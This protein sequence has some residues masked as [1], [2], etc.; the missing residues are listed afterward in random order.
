MECPFCKGTIGYYQKNIQSYNQL[1][2]WEGKAIDAEEPY[3]VRTCKRIYCAE[4]NKNITKYV[5]NKP[6]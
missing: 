5:N 3:H 1:Y 4:C 6:K 2:D